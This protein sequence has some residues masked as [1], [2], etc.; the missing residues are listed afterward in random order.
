MYFTMHYIL[1]HEGCEGMTVTF[2]HAR[3]AVGLPLRG[4]QCILNV[5]TFYFYKA[6]YI[7][8]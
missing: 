7:K 3:A 2:G 6:V 5:A 4:Y 1:K 8:I